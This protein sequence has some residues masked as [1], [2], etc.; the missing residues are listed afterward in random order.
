MISLTEWWKEILGAIAI[1]LTLG[2]FV[3]YTRSILRGETKP[4]LFSWIIW[5]AT[6]SIVFLAQLEGGAG[7][8]AWSIGVS[9]AATILIAGLAYRKNADRSITTL[10][11]VFLVS[12]MTSL[13]F[14][15]LTSDPFWAVLILTTVDLL[16]FG[17][18]L[19]KAHDFPFEEALSFYWLFAIRNVIAILALEHY[20]WTTVLFPAATGIASLALVGMVTRRRQVLPPDPSPDPPRAPT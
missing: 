14:W 17:P 5:G 1:V 11:W 9:G 2:S 13:P 6:T 8:G 15:Y 7:V 4:H 10:D 3:P 12:A 16:G 18:T 19:R 20:S